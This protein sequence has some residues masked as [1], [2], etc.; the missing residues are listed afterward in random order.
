MG[1]DLATKAFQT[2]RRGIAWFQIERRA[3]KRTYPQGVKIRGEN[4]GQAGP[5]LLDAHFESVG[6]IAKPT[7]FRLQPVHT[8]KQYEKRNGGTTGPRGE[9][10]RNQKKSC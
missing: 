7:G 4:D 2:E 6:W 8:A 1:V 5:L 10:S 9:G 3:A